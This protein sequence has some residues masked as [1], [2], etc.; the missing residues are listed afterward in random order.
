MVHLLERRH[1]DRFREFMD[2][3]LPN[4]RLH[5]EELNRLPLAHEEWGY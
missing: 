1:N 2:R 3:F 4:W 5:R